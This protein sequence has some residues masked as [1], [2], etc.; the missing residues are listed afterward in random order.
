MKKVIVEISFVENNYSAHVPLLPGC[1]SVGKTEDEVIANIKEAIAF[2]LEGMREDGEEIP[3][4]FK[5]E[6]EVEFAIMSK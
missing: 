4:E 3:E 5:G 1:V 6:M 2:H